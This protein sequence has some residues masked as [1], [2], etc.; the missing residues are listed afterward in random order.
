LVL[1]RADFA[2]ATWMGWLVAA[3]PV[4]L[5]ATGAAIL[6]SKPLKGSMPSRTAAA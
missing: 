5:L 3:T 2:P 1:S 6:A 4:I